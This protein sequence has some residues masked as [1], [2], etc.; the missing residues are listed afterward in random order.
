MAVKTIDSKNG[1][2]RLQA[3]ST[4]VIRVNYTDTDSDEIYINNGK[5]G[6]WDDNNPEEDGSGSTIVVAETYSIAEANK[7]MNKIKKT[8]DQKYF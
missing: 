3:L 4:D 6:T 2:T 1:V 5:L 8:T 7:E